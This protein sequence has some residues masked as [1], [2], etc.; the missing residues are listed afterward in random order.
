MNIL[1]K[2]I[3]ILP[4]AMLSA[5]SLTSCSDEFLEPKPL[6]FFEPSN[7]FTTQSGMNA[8]LAMCDRQL[9][10][11]YIDY[12]ARDSDNPIGV[13]YLFSE[14]M[15]WGKT[16]GGS[17]NNDNLA[18]RMTPNSCGTA[19]GYAHKFWSW[20]YTGIKYANGIISSLPNVSDISDE[21][22]NQ[23]MGRAYFHRA[24]HYYA[25]VFDYGD[26]P[27]VTK[28]PEVPKENYQST[29]R[30][31]IIKKMI[32]DLEFA[33]KWVPTQAEMTH[34]GMI[35]KECCKHLLV[36]YYLADGRFSDA[37]NLATDLIERS[38]LSLMTESFGTNTTQSQGAP[39]TWQVTRN[40]IWDLHRPENKMGSFN[41]ECILGLPNLSEQ[42]FVGYYSNRTFGPYWNDGKIITPDGKGAV[43]NW[44]RSNKNYVEDMDWVRAFGRGIATFRPTYF[45]QHSLW[46]VNG[47]EDTQDLRHNSEVGNWV[48]MEQITYN[49]DKSSAFY[50]KGM[51]LFAEEDYVD[52]NGNVVVEK[53]RLLVPDTIRS[54]FDFPYYKYYYHDAK[55]ESNLD[56]NNFKGVTTGGNG[57]L[58]L[59]RLA[60]TYL[61]RAEAKFYQGRASEAT[62]DLNIIRRRA[63]CSQEYS[64][65]VTIGD[66]MNERARELLLEEFRHQELVRVS[67][68]LAKTGLPDE[69]GN[70]YGEDWDKQDG[71]DAAGGSYWYQR[72]MHYSYYNKGVVS[73]GGKEMNYRIDKHNLLWAVPH[74]A[75]VGNKKGILKQNFGYEGYDENAPVWNT[76]QEAV[77]DEDN[78]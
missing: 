47:I 14:L 31:A 60:E 59:Y 74:S 52:K 46:V 71:T 73:T 30:E 58:Y 77:A 44:A 16:D 32:E 19:N 25:L 6:S 1:H 48:N 68:L 34:Y 5:A 51:Q 9:R 18:G 55:N 2:F 24:Y 78:Y 29:K 8:A 13:D 76:W 7:V 33:V 57:N 43:Q 10:N 11:N 28:L 36:K 67:M 70:T 37:E 45:A 3:G 75:I 27:L 17:S 50:G 15:L 40:V 62:E 56:E 66:I 39:Q 72:I 64:G 61:L 4:M 65:S 53:G 49:K 54:W 42:S 12:Q 38:G 35:N 23:T 41:R 63:K 69:W 22:R 26:V 20:S 21:L